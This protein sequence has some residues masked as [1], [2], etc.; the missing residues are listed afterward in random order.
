MRVRWRKLSIWT[1]IFVSLQVFSGGKGLST[2]ATVNF[3]GRSLET[4]CI[5]RTF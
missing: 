2:G 3:L 4:W 5:H 1:A